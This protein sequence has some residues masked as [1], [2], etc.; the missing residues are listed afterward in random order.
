M[1]NKITAG[2]QPSLSCYV[3]ARVLGEKDIYACS[4][5]PITTDVTQG[6]RKL[7]EES[8]PFLSLYRHT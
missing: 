8:K 4:Y 2:R 1:T 5:V 6:R 7:E 3:S